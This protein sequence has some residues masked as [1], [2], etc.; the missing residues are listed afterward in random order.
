MVQQKKKQAYR[1]PKDNW[2]Q[3]LKNDL[4]QCRRAK[5]RGQDFCPAHLQMAKREGQWN[6]VDA[7]D[8]YMVP[9]DDPLRIDTFQD[10]VDQQNYVYY[11]VMKD[12][13][14][15]E[16]AE[17]LIKILKTIADTMQLR[18]KHD[19]A[20]QAD[21]EQARTTGEQ[22][23][24]VIADEKIRELLTNYSEFVAK[25]TDPG[26]L[27]SVA[28]SVREITVGGEP[29]P[30]KEEVEEPE[31]EPEYYPDPEPE[32]EVRAEDIFDLRRPVLDSFEPDF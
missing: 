1:I 16:A 28:E 11:R 30:V 20:T 10:V 2:C 7:V 5:A 6:A 27:D 29:E 21:L 19:P 15:L 3:H 9:E 12:G 14:A 24:R 13:M 26:Y 25:I 23:G 18:E 31:P 22:V 8:V 17:T 32:P 4:K